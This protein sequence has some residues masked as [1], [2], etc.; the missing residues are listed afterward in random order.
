M[1]GAGA[2]DDE[3]AVVLAGE[4]AGGGVA[5][6][7]NRL[8]GLGAELDLVAEELGLHERV[9]LCG[10]TSA[11]RTADGA[12]RERRTPM[13]R[14]SWMYFCIFS[15]SSSGTGVTILEDLNMAC[16]DIVCGG[17]M[18]CRGCLSWGSWERGAARF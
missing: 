10:S 5:R 4:D 1:D 6:G 2:D 11:Q 12:G 14:R 8:L 17:E 18:E 9:V 15:L 3:D 16:A 7:G 13:T